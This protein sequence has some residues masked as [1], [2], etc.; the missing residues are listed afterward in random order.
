MGDVCLLTFLRSW[1]Q[2]ANGLGQGGNKVRE[3]T[4]GDS[5]FH[6]FLLSLSSNVKGKVGGRDERT[7]D[8]DTGMRR[9]RVE[10]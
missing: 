6:F 9:K 1:L 5:L 4:F 2:V 3:V 8:G 10:Y 7:K